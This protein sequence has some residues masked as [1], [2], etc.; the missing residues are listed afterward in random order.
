VRAVGRSIWAS[1]QENE[2]RDDGLF[3][4]H[5]YV[6]QVAPESG[7]PTEVWAGVSIG[8]GSIETVR[9]AGGRWVLY[10]PAAT[11][12]RALTVAVKPLP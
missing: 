4:T 12:R 10:M 1:W 3:D 6:K 7:V 2:P 11:A 9:G 5:A 8:P